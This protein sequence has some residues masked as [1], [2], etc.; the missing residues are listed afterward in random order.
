MDS[1]LSEANV[2]FFWAF[3]IIIHKNRYICNDLEH[4][5]LRPTRIRDLIM[6]K[7]IKVM[8]MVLFVVGMTTL[9]SCTKSNEELILGKWKLDT[10]S[11]TYEGSS[12]E[13][14]VADLAALIGADDEFTDF[15]V[16]FKDNGYVYMEDESAAYSID[17]DKLTVTQDG[18]SIE[19]TISKISSSSMTLEAEEDG[20]VMDLTFKKA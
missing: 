16:E 5:Q 20:V 8:A 17:G 13:M 12:F 15:I 3:I 2:W 6:K 4:Q 18:E 10:I 7:A 1:S 14:T 19:M 9:S 11:A